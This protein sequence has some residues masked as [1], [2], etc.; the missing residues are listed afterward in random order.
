MGLLDKWR[1]AVGGKATE[2]S[3][4]FTESYR[5]H[6]GEALLKKQSELEAFAAELKSRDVNI[7]EREANLGK[8]YLV[9]RTHIN[10]LIGVAIVAAAYF[11]YYAV[12]S[13]LSIGPS[14]KSA[15]SGSSSPGSEAV[16]STSL[17]ATCQL[18]GVA[19]YKDIGS[20]PYLST[21]EDADKKVEGM[22]RRSG[23]MAFTR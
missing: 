3:G 7:S 11:G 9:R 5:E 10:L 21:G 13:K 1:G 22:C 18:M 8:Y 20:Y 12:E 4:K 14:V 6:V 19:Y 16:E 23:G 17:Y 2:L 15:T